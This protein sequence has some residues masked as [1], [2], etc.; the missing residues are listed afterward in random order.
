[1]IVIDFLLLLD[2]ILFMFTSLFT[3]PSQVVRI[4]FRFLSSNMPSNFLDQYDPQQVS[5]L[6]EPLIVVNDQDEV[7]GQV[8]KKDAHLLANIEQKST[9][10]HRAFSF[11]LFDH[12][13]S[14]SR[15]VLQQRAPEKITL[16]FIM[17]KYLL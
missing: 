14:P 1:M 13:S 12:S 5:L 8:T 2:F 17:G 16:S 7:L 10:I 11:F 6:Y 4:S 3:R 15:L 9:L